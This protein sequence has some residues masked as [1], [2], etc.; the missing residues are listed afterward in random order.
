[1]KKKARILLVG[2]GIMPIPSNGWGAVETVVWQQKQ[3]LEALGHKVDIL[4]SRGLKA[5]LLA[6]PWSYDVVHLHYDELAKFWNNLAKALRLNL[7]VTTHYGY[8]AWPD[9][10]DT[11]YKDIFSELMQSKRLLVLSEDIKTTFLEAGYKGWVEVL[12]NG[13][14]VDDI[15]YSHK[16]NGSV[17]CLGKIEPRKRQSQ[18][19][20]IIKGSAVV[21]DFIGPKVDPLFKPDNQ[22]S[23]Y[24]GTWSREEVRSNLTNYS[25]L[26]LLSD[27]EAHPL[28]VGEALAA[29]LSV[30]VSPEASA[31]I[32]VGAPYAIIVKSDDQIVSSLQ[33]AVSENA[34]LRDGIREYA[35]KNLSWNTMAQVYVKIVISDYEH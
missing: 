21:C 17:L 6:M 7:V 4:N 8:A 30:V 10:W 27:G 28:V 25:A 34:K 9:K 23:Y 18:I 16:G 29:G 26:V 12:P 13:T 24:K 1:M 20:E 19:V 15:R 31:N 14:E 3:A 5:A 22:N 11:Y 32:A 2:P 33:K 35:E